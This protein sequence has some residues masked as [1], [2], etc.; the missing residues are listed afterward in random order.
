[1]A[2]LR[3]SSRETDITGWYGNETT[4]GVI[5][6]EIRSDAASIVSLL[7]SRVTSALCSE[8]SAKQFNNIRLSFLVFPDHCA[9][10]EADREAF[11]VLYPDLMHEIDAKK[12]ALLAKR[13]LD[14]VG[15]LFALMLFLP[16]LLVIA[17][18]IKLTSRGPLL[19][20][21]QR[22]GQYGKS[23]TFLKFRSMYVGADQRIHEAYVKQ[24][25]SVR[26]GAGDSGKNDEIYKIKADPRVTADGR[27]IRKT[28][29]DE[30]PQ[31][32]NCLMGQM[33][34]V[35][36]RPPLPY[37]FTAYQVWHRRRLAVKPGITGLWQVKGRSRVK[38]DEMVRMDLEYA[39]SWSLWLDIK[40]L[41]QTP[42]AVLT[43]AGA[44]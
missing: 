4:I 33:A 34:L 9:G 14:I 11:S 20:K 25:I 41:L 16:V 39:R 10:P 36:P 8:L 26:S 28:S 17:A 44:Y 3:Q 18:A 22:L 19:F 43:G 7:S 2:A 1:L 29:L 30:L 40:L 5:F 31:F 27:F 42:G 21:Q 38:F 35:G 12:V 6:T 32:F 24:F 15:S 23:F 13:C 37:E